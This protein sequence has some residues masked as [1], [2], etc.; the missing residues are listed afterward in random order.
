MWLVPRVGPLPPPSHLIYG[1]D[2][3]DLGLGCRPPPPPPAPPP[4]PPPPSPPQGGPSRSFRGDRPPPPWSQHIGISL[5]CK[6]FCLKTVHTQYVLVAACSNTCHQGFF[7]DHSSPTRWQNVAE[8]VI[9]QQCFLGDLSQDYVHTGLLCA[10]YEE[11][12]CAHH[13]GRGQDKQ[14]SNHQ[15]T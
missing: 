5:A 8:C 12:G 10:E 15:N 4:L 2:I 6:L 13:Q 7:P 9:A 1:V 14:C 11:E 3:S